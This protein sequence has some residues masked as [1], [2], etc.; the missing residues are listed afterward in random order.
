MRRNERGIIA[1]VLAFSMTAALLIV[2]IVVDI[3]A[4]RSDRQD[5]QRAVDA[6]AA[7]GA[8]ALPVSGGQTA[9]TTAMGYLTLNLPDITSFSGV[10]CSTFPAVCTSTTASV[11]DTGTAGDYTVTIVHPVPDAHALMA[12]SAIGRPR[13]TVHSTDGTPCER[14]GVQL[15]LRREPFFAAVA[16][17]GIKTTTVHAVAI[18]KE[19]TGAS[20]PINLL[21]LERRRCRAIHVSGGGD[22]VVQG[23]TDPVTGAVQ[24]GI[25]AIDSDG[26]EPCDGGAGTLDVDGS[27]A[28]ARADGPTGCAGEL[29]AGSGQAC[30][31]IE[32]FAA[33][34]PGNND[35]CDGSN[36]LPACQST[37]NV[38]PSPVRTSQLR[39][40]APIDY[41]YNCK[42]SYATE[43][44]YVRQPIRGC[45][46]GTPAYIDELKAYAS[47][48]AAGAVTGWNVYGDTAS[49]PCTIDAAPVTLP[50]GNWYV[51]CN[52]LIVRQ[53]VTFAGGNIVF[54]GDVVIEA[55]T[56][57]LTINECVSLCPVLSFLAGGDFA[58]ASYSADAAWVVFR[59]GDGIR[60][61][62][63]GRLTVN[64][65]VLV[66]ADTGCAGSLSNGD[67]NGRCLQLEGGSGSLR[68]TAPREGP[69]DDLSL[70]SE[71]TLNHDYGG[72]ASMDLEGVLFAPSSTVV[73]R[74]NGNQQQARAQFVAERL[75][76]NGSGAL[77]VRPVLGRSVDF[78][79]DPRATIIR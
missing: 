4:L 12:S 11:S 54:D 5:D 57:H 67:P 36:E 10:D 45:D 40:R 28:N 18:S 69:F 43:P 68:W 23:I 6:A 59:T 39:T 24:P 48:V 30:G 14:I 35:F 44:W 27:P 70:W 22:L 47:N 75:H 41:R 33:G 56:G 3:G 38:R 60:K 77:L 52:R 8:L 7:A 16:G 32:L 21:V 20:R 76:V 53:P 78:P 34:V 42:P 65:A 46:D 49:E 17:A 37:G 9:C 62:G 25:M 58:E 74:G 31:I 13:P 73:Y 79:N 71:G 2:A 61:A 1:V 63:V 26:S 50:M 55:S 66:F 19:E 51:N 15:A 64:D 72:Q 29:L